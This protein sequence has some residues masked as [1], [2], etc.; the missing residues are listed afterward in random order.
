MKNKL[1]KIVLIGSLV[2]SWLTASSTD[3]YKSIAD[4]SAGLTQGIQA[5]VNDDTA[6]INEDGTVTVNVLGNDEPGSVIKSV[7]T[8]TNDTGEPLGEVSIVDGQIQFT[9]APNFDELNA[10]ES[11]DVTFTYTM[12]DEAGNTAS[13]DVTVTVTGE[14]NDLTYVSEAAGYQNVVGYYELDENGVPSSDITIVIDDQN[15]MTSGE[16]LADLDPNRSYGFMI[17]ANGASE[18]DANSVVTFDL[19]GDTPTVLIDGGA[20]SHPVYHDTPEWNLDGKDHFVFEQDPNGGMTTYIEDLPNLGDSDFI[21]VVLHSDIVLVDKIGNDAN[22]NIVYTPDV[23]FSGSNAVTVSVKDNNGATTIQEVTNNVTDE[24]M[25]LASISDPHTGNESGVMGVD[26]T[27]STISNSVDTDRNDIV[28]GIAEADSEGNYSSTT[29]EL[30]DGEH[31]S[32][33]TAQEIEKNILKKFFVEAAVG[34]STMDITQHNINGQMTLSIE[35]ET[36]GENY[37]IGIGYRHSKNYFS[38]LGLNYVYYNDAR[39]YNY[40]YSFNKSFDILLNPYFGIAVG[41]SSITITKSQLRDVPI[42]DESGAKPI[43]GVQAGFEQFI[44]ENFNLFMQYQYLKSRHITQLTSI[45]AVSEIERE[46]H[47]NI[48]FGVRYNFNWR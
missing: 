13:A 44:W 21:D 18:V 35:P 43:Y 45:G 34:K 4:D 10:G 16:H 36:N 42:I 2:F 19:S 47:Q 24:G 27:I 20:V 8:P 3:T 46:N 26:D 15:G 39:I 6:T 31:T 38:S 33:I 1:I 25:V 23:N 7:E 30:D 14:A 48:M 17:I 41:T 40:L 9:P 29:T 11:A 12:E 28:A 22:E 32:T 37:N 5:Q